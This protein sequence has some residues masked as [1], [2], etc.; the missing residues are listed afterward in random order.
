MRKLFPKCLNL[1][2]FK[3]CLHS[4]F[5]GVVITPKNGVKILGTG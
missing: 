3:C 2:G 1:C 4:K 5:E